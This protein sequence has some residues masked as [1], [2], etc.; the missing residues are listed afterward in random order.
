LK[1]GGARIPLPSSS[2]LLPHLLRGGVDYAKIICF[3]K[4]AFYT[5]ECLDVNM[6]KS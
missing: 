2:L 4:E 1:K 6:E 3:Q 5:K